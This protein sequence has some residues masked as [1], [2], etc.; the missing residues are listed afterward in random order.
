MLTLPLRAL[1]WVYKLL[2]SPVIGPRCRFLPTCSDYALEALQV[3]GL[4]CGSSLALRR[5]LRCH[6]WGGSGYDPVPPLGATCRE[7]H[8]HAQR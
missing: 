5:L 4:F 2:L 3:H 1:I 6:P 8:F 7:P